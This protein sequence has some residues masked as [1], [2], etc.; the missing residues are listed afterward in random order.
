MLLF[1]TYATRYA[2]AGA[3]AASR[4]LLLIFFA[5]AIAAFR[6]LIRHGIVTSHAQRL[7][8][9]RHDDAYAMMPIIDTPFRCYATLSAAFRR[10]RHSATPFRHYDAAAAA[11]LPLLLLFSA[12]DAI[13]FF[14]FFAAFAIH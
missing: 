7:P 14:F 4:R 6:C 3:M 2:A 12:A 13:D 11:D 5:Y 10:F 9:R 8:W 1:F